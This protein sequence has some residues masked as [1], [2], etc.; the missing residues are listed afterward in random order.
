MVLDQIGARDIAGWK[1]ALFGSVWAI[2]RADARRKV[3][4]A[5]Q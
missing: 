5:Q 2:L 1:T 4:L 3:T